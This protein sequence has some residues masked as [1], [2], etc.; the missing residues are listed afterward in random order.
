MTSLPFDKKELI[1]VCQMDEQWSFVGDKKNQ[2]WL[3]Y[4]WEPRYRKVIA[5]VFG[6]RTTETLKKLIA[7]LKPYKFKFYCTDDWKPYT[8]ALAKV[9]HVVSKSVMQ[10]IERNNLTLRTRLK[11]LNR[12]TICFSR[13]EVMHDKVIGEFISRMWYQPV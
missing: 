8:S 9:K 4:T 6:S 11:R 3:F 5:H 1:L 12:K 7:L 13:S 10:S 2:R